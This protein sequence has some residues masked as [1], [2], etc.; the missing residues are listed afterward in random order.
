MTDNNSNDVNKFVKSLDSQ[1]SLKDLG[2]LSYFL[3]IE[4]AYTPTGLVLSQRKYI[5]DYRRISQKALLHL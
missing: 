3:G 1:F 4:V 5:L 2:K